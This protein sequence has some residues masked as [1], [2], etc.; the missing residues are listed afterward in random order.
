MHFRK[1]RLATIIPTLWA[2]TASAGPP[3]LTDDPAPTDTR[4]WEIYA[5]GAGTKTT[6][7][8]DGVV[9]LDLNY[10]PINDVQLTAT[11][12]VEFAHGGGV[13]QSAVG[14]VE[15]GMKYGFA[16]KDLE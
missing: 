9:G 3:Y 4:H 8:F 15:L 14:D 7:G 11:L 16:Y 1:I 6:G 10:G 12:P 13:Q 2:S 5:F